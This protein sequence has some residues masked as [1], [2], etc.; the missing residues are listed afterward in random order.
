MG[1]GDGDKTAL[2]AF[3]ENVET[4]LSSKEKTSIKPH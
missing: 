3:N 1:M 2:F 4:L